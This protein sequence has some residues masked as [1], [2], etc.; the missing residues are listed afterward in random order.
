MGIAI[1]ALK[2]TL[3]KINF[4]SLMDL[5]LSVVSLTVSSITSNN[6]LLLTVPDALLNIKLINS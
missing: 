3:V 6:L 1:I 5:A 4:F 2:S